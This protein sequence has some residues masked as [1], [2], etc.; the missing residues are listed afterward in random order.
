MDDIKPNQSLDGMQG[1]KGPQPNGLSDTSSSSND[2]N[3]GGLNQFNDA[4][5]APDNSGE[6]HVNFNEQQQEE[7]AKPSGGSGKG[8]KVLLTLFVILFVAA[9]GAAVYFYMESNK[10]EPKAAVV[11]VSKVQQ[12]NE[13]LTY[14]NKTLKTQNTQYQ[15]QIKSLTT[16]ANQLK[17]KCGSGCSAIVIPQ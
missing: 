1:G 11:D 14:D 12:E 9:A 16:T 3:T 10:E 4:D 7:P 13:A 17:T 15:V 5:Y 6:Q 2:A 8:L